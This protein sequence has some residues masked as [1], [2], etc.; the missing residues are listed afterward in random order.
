MK[1]V[2]IQN[3]R[4]EK[5]SHEGR[6]IARYQNKVVFVEGAL[7]GEE[8]SW[9]LLKR[10]SNLDLAKVC[11]I[12][13]LSP[14]RQSHFCPHYAE[15]GGCSLQHLNSAAQVRFK[16]GVVDE[17][18][19]HYLHENVNCQPLEAADCP[20]DR[21]ATDSAPS[22]LPWDPPIVAD[23][24][25]QTMH[26]R[27]RARIGVKY[28][29]R[30]DRLI[31]GFHQRAGRYLADLTRCPILCA[32]VGEQIETLR[33]LLR[34]LSVF[35]RIAQ[36]EITVGD[37]AV[38]IVIRNL[39]P[40]TATDL[41]QL[42][43]FAQTY[44]LQHGQQLVFYLQPGGPTS[45]QPALLT[46]SS[47]PPSYTLPAFDLTLQFSPVSFIQINA[48]INQKLVQR[49]VA[50]LAPQPEDYIIDFYCGIGNFTLPI[51]RASGARLLGLEGDT[52]AVQLAAQNVEL[53]A[54]ISTNPAAK[55]LYPLDPARIQFR[56]LDLSDLTAL[57]QVRAELLQANKI[58]LDPPRTGTAEL[59]KFILSLP[60][61]PATI[62]YVSCNPITLARDC[63]ILAQHGYTITNIAIADMYPHTSHV[64]TIVR[65]SR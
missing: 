46:D 60:H 14:E 28:L 56:S 9:Q 39:S 51:A 29:H 45:V 53:N 2:V 12:Q 22:A 6:G 63:A 19:N 23:N 15:C 52:A 49:A 4:I 11:T 38:F 41:T 16:Q 20:L 54:A 61:Q 34:Q 3:G 10:K 18:C 50:W 59:L 5:L 24:D 32:A 40:L 13:Q 31:I 58:L 43:H 33:G 35:D 17:L 65:L 1:T 25:A 57:N 55:Q 37:T 44:Q 30:K 64:E 48:A 21:S 47:I 7:P 8:V 42:A 36:L 62:L 26:Y 27:R